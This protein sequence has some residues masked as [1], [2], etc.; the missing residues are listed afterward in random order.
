VLVIVDDARPERLGDLVRSLLPDHPDLEVHA[1]A[2][3]LAR[4]AKGALVILVPDPAH[5]DWLNQERPVFSNRE[6][7]VIL[8]SDTATTALLSRCA[9]DF[10]SWIS[11]RVECPAGPPRFAIHRLRAALLARSRGVAWLRGDLEATFREAL[12]GRPLVRVTA[13]L[14][15]EEMVAAAKPG[16]KGWVAWS[17][18]DG[19]FRLRRVRWAAT[20]A[21]RRARMVLVDPSVEAPGFALV[22]GE[23]LPVQVA[24]TRLEEAGAKHAGRLAALLDLEPDAVDVAV[25]LLRAGEDEAA[26]ERAA[27]NAEDPGAAVAR[28][29]RARGIDVGG[30]PSVM[31]GDKVEALLGKA[32]R[33][34]ARWVD[35]ARAAAEDMGDPRAGVVWARRGLA[36]EPGATEAIEMAGENLLQA[37]ALREAGKLLQEAAA[38]YG[39]ATSESDGLD[40]ADALTCLASIAGYDGRHEEAH[41]LTERAVDLASRVGDGDNLQHAGAL[42]VLGASLLALGQKAEA[43]DRLERAIEISRRV[44]GEGTPTHV[45]SCR[46]MALATDHPNGHGETIEALRELAQLALKSLGVEHP[47]YAWVLAAEGMMLSAAQQDDEAGQVLRSGLSILE[48]VLGDSHALLVDVLAALGADALGRGRYAEAESYFKRQSTVAEQTWGP[49]HIRYGAALLNISGVQLRGGKTRAALT[50]GLRALEVLEVA[51]GAPVATIATALY[52]VSAALFR[53]GDLDRAMDYAKRAVDVARGVPKS[54]HSPVLQAALE[55][56]SIQE[57][58]RGDPEAAAHAREAL[59]LLR[60]YPGDNP[61]LMSWLPILERIAMDH[62]IR[63]PAE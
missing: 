6:L 28:M 40:H 56:L 33:G 38:R 53:L 2:P 1:K 44:S 43:R 21:G 50:R 16:G 26:I 22:R 45:E 13:S 57:A 36:A 63:R 24:L 31:S 23:P 55:A 39:G 49:K 4:A 54:E 51:P 27:M 52:G 25:A 48:K 41:A 7:R 62:P 10:F 47:A 15:Y 30:A 12:P 20:E 58:R 35:V 9:P 11:H 3:R 42:S 19:P 37:G 14:P 59:A 5:A 18:V 34:E 29:A 17:D 46:L 61:A 8:F 60:E 32:R